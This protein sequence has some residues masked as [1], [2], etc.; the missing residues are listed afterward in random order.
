[1]STAMLTR[2]AHY[3]PALRWGPHYRREQAIHDLMAALTVTLMLVPQALAYAILAG[4][5]PQVGLYASLLPLIVYA[6]LGTSATLAVGPVAV[7]AL[8][9]A[10]AVAP[11]S[12]QSPALGLQAALILACLS[13]LFLM[14]AGMFKLGFLANFLS[15]PVM[16]GF[17]AGASLVIASSQLPTLLGIQAE[18]SHV[19]ALWQSM[20]GQWPQIHLATA[21][22]S[23]LTLLLLVLARRQGQS[24]LLSLGC[25]PFWAQAL[26]RAVPALL[27]L[28]GTI[29]MHAGWALFTGVRTVGQIPAGLP[30][31]ALPHGS[32]AMWQ[33]LLAPALLIS[34]IGT[35]ES[36][37]VAQ[38]L[39]MKRR[40]RIDPDQE[41]IALGGANLAASLSG[42]QP[43]TGGVSRSVVNMDAGAQTPAAGL[44]TA[45][46]MWLATVFLASWLSAL[47]RFILASTIIVAV[48]SLVDGRVFI[49]TWRRNRSD[50]AALL[51]TFMITLLVDIEHGISAGVLLSMA[52]HLYRSSRPHIAIVGQVPG[53]EHFRNVARHAVSVCPDVITLRVDE[54]LY[55]A[56]ARYL[57]QKVLEVVAD[58]PAL[59]HVILMCSAVNE[60]DGSALEVLEVINHHLSALGIGFHLSEVKGPVMDMLQ[61]A[62]LRQQLNGEIY[63]TQHQAY[64]A[65]S[66]H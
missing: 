12:A 56:N 35:V 59:K 21:M 24:L 41:L 46:G 13:G 44:F 15:H 6:L 20:L 28:I 14:L 36:I 58:N 30:A 5:P 64:A 31:L 4:L 62:P 22:L 17:I 47:P 52:M 7:A 38:S 66:C 37:S 34:I 10:T 29:A 60:V 3:V 48:M 11:Y 51:V 2:L 57:E 43:V 19:L 61:H 16:S 25:S 53:T 54:S 42:G 18:G 55:F 23:V 63:L 65:L 39:A 1:M 32:L 9:T 40:E 50:F 8:M 49:E 27:V 33:S 45:L 26:V